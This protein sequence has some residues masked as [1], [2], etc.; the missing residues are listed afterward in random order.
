MSMDKQSPANKGPVMKMKSF[1]VKDQDL[2]NFKLQQ[3]VTIVI[4]GTI[5][6]LANSRSGM[7]MGMDAIASSAEITIGIKTIK[8]KDGSNAF[9][10]L[11][12]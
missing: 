7:G 10:A 9:S 5:C 8:I 6:E 12:D 2:K 1:D 3:D 4:T 11:A